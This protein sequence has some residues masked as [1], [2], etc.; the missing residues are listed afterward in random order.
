[1]AMKIRL[2][3]PEHDLHGDQ[4][5]QREPGGRVGSQGHQIVHSNRGVR[6]FSDYRMCYLSGLGLDANKKEF[7]HE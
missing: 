2:S 3:M 5:D 1:M 6:Y 7:L 4:G